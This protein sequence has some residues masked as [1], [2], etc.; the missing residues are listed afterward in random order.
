M[1]KKDS[2]PKTSDKI[3]FGKKSG[4][5]LKKSLNKH[6]NREHNYRGQGR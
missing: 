3:S 6:D 5:K 1:A 2:A 4:G